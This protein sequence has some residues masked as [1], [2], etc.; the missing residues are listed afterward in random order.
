MPKCFDIFSKQYLE[1]QND[2]ST[3]AGKHEVSQLR[4][5]LGSFQTAL[6]A[7]TRITRRDF[8]FTTAVR[9]N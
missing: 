5:C 8:D 7:R 2:C 4:K 1:F 6:P 3:N 9:V